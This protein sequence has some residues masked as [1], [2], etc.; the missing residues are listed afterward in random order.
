MVETENISGRR[1]VIFDPGDD[2]EISVSAE[3]D[4]FYFREGESFWTA[5]L[6]LDTFS[7]K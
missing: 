7:K 2:P 3:D 5:P 4:L 1:K 6:R